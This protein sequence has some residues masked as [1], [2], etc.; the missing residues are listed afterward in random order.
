MKARSRLPVSKP[1]AGG[2]GVKGRGRSFFGHD[3]HDTFDDGLYILYRKF[4]VYTHQASLG[5]ILI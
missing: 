1:T 2:W 5:D 4:I 3:F